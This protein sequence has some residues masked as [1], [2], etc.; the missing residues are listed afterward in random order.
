VLA[1]GTIVSGIVLGSST[2]EPH[3]PGHDIAFIWQAA[4]NGIIATAY[5]VLGVWWVQ[6][7][8]LH[9]LGKL[10]GSAFFVACAF[11]HIDLAIHS[12]QHAP[13]MIEPHMFWIHGLQAIVDWTFVVVAWRYRG[14]VVESEPVVR[15]REQRLEAVERLA[16]V[17][18][19]ERRRWARELHDQTLQGLAAAH[20][21]LTVALETDGPPRKE[22]IEKAITG[23]EGEITALRGLITELRPA[24]LEQL[25]LDA[26]LQNLATVCGERYG[27]D[28]DVLVNLPA[29]N[30]HREELDDELEATIYRIAQEALNNAARHA[31]A[32]HAIVRVG[33]DANDIVVTVAD[34]G[35]GFDTE[36]STSGFGMIGMHERSAILGGKIDI[37]S[38]DG[39]GTTVRATLPLARTAIPA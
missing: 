26:G 35:Q 29:M 11:T 23:V 9:P 13:L 31:E 24:V 37:D 18:E 30:R 10:A 12:A 34:D 17:R 1:A 2:T 28:V 25:G 3:L 5:I 38:E 16:D 15:A 20:I 14:L 7:L 36:A 21:G 6:Q 19:E 39:K 32:S 22:M 33:R 4:L 27:L 8:R